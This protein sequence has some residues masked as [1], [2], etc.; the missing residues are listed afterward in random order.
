MREECI[1]VFSVGVWKTSTKSEL[2][3]CVSDDGRSA[4]LAFV[5]SED[6]KVAVMR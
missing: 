1:A 2:G 4:S 3:I 5:G 6:R